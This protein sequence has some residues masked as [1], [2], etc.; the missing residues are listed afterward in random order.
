MNAPVF[1]S[2]LSAT[3]VAKATA[4]DACETLAAAMAARDTGKMQLEG[5]RALLNLFQS[6]PN[7]A[8][9]A[10]VGGVSMILNA[11]ESH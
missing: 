1:L 9:L 2:K 6:Q 3:D 8:R 10:A 7:K 5:C 11:I 4:L